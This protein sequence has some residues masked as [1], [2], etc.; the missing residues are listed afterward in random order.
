MISIIGGGPV[1]S[2]T[3][4][5]LAKNKDVHVFEEHDTIGLPVQCTG[6]IT[7]ALNDLIKIRKS[8]LVNRISRARIF[9][10]D[11]NFIDVGFKDK[12]FVIDRRKFDKYIAEMA[13]D[14][15]VKFHLNH[16]FTGF[17]RSGSSF[18]LKF[19]G[20][21]DFVSEKL[22]GADGPMSG[23]AKSAGIFGK[24]RFIIGLQ[25]RVSSEFD[26]DLIGFY[27]DKRGF[28]WIT[29]ESEKVA[30]VGVVSYD[31]PN[32]YFKDFLKKLG[33]CKVREYNSGIIPVYNPNV[34]SQKKN[35]FLVGDAA[36]QVK[37][38][39]F[40]GLVPGLI[41]AEELSKAILKNKNYSKLWKKRIGRDLWLSLLIRKRLDRFSNEKYNDLVRLFKK[42][43]L[44]KIIESNDRDFPSKFLFKLLVREPRLLKFV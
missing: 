6:L 41:C 12:N 2:Y 35:L 31:N 9:S 20:K 38:T 39:T 26:K 3:A 36:T 18:K 43:H 21:K 19:K 27:L 34:V 15:G 33:R 28:G 37:A 5:L 29:P 16:N 17:K 10:P 23:V 40:G 25:A 30:R 11:G 44:R 4:C 22:I 24:R 42:K 8:F 1:G 7:K 32:V 13:E 14:R